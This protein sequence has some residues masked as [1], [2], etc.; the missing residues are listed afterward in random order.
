MTDKGT[1]KEKTAAIAKRLQAKTG[2][3][4]DRIFNYS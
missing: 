3:M 2:T 1:N 4:F